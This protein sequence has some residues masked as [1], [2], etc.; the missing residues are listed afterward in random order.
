MKKNM[1]RKEF[2]KFLEQF[3]K[4]AIICTDT[5][6]HYSTD[7]ITYATLVEC[8]DNNKNQ[9]LLFIGNTRHVGNLLDGVGKYE[10]WE[11][12]LEELKILKALSVY[13]KHQNY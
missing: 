1:T 6:N 4:D 11:Y 3:P 10:Q 12:N 8:E 7:G 9:K 13:D 2:Q 5:N